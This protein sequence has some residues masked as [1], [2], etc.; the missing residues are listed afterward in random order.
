MGEH[1]VH[2]AGDPVTFGLPGLRQPPLLLLRGPPRLLRGGLG[3]A[4]P[5]PDQCSR[6]QHDRHARESEQGQRPGRHGQVRPGQRREQRRQSEPGRD[7]PCREE[8]PVG[9]DREQ[10]DQRHPGRGRRVDAEQTG[11]RGKS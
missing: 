1:I 9:R 8:P 2:L 6:S 3:E 7:H 10:R 5:E 11:D 4:P